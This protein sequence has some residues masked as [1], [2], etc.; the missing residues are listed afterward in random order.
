MK[1]RFITLFLLSI[2]TFHAV[3]SENENRT[4]GVDAPDWENHHV[5]HINREPARAAFIAFSQQ[6]GDCSL[7]LNGNW[8]FHWS[9]TPEGR[10]ADFFTPKFDDSSWKDFPVPA[11]WEVN[12]FGTPIYVSSGYPF[13]IDPPR[14]TSTPNEKYTAFKERNPTVNIAVRSRCLPTGNLTGRFSCVSMVFKV[15]FTSGSMVN[16][17]D[18]A[19]EAWN[20]V[21]LM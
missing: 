5:L 19:R 4:P 21:S 12:G 8:K 3:W 16:G 1:K 2:L 9:P 11:N 14:V 15:H 17:W 13:K 7:T 10:I 6:P 18:T 20:R